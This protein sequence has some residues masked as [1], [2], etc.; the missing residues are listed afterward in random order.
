MGWKEEELKS[1]GRGEVGR[2]SGI[3]E[4]GRKSGI[5][6]EEIVEFGDEERCL[7]KPTVAGELRDEFPEGDW[8][9]C[10]E[11]ESA[12]WYCWGRNGE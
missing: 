5:G 9:I 3:G 2:K 8:D 1:S 7:P 12:I 4:V 10:E 6:E 11:G